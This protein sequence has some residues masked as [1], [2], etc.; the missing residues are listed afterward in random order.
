MSYVCSIE[1]LF[2]PSN[3]IEDQG[4]LERTKHRFN[5]LT[6]PTEA[7][8][9]TIALDHRS[10]DHPAR[11]AR[12]L[13]AVPDLMPTLVLRLT[14]RGKVVLLSA[15][16]VAVAILVIMLGSS[17]AASNHAGTPVQTTVV[18]VLPGQ[19]LWQIAAAANPNGD[20]RSTV[21]DIVRLNSLPN[22][23]ALQLGSEIA[24]PVY[25]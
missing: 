21:D 1:R 25:K 17:T 12:H 16:V 5:R 19:T 22:A 7:L 8:M 2:A 24:V 13:S 10:V 15:A 9:S 11:P 23:S 14:R 3:D 4:S 20:I 18:T 6:S